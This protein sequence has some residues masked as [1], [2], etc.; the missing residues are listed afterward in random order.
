[1]RVWVTRTQPGADRTAARLR[2]LGHEPV[3]VPLLRVRRLP[4]TPDLAGVAALAFTS[5][6]GVAAYADTTEDRS[7]PVFAVGDATAAAAR[8]AGFPQVRSAGGD[9]AALTTLIA[10]AAP[11]PGALL[12]VAGRPR[13]GDLQGALVRLGVT[14]RTVTVYETTPTGAPTPERVDA[15][16]AHSPEAARRLAERVGTDAP[17][18]ALFACISDAAAAPLR[19]AGVARLAVAA[20]PD[21]AALL[22]LLT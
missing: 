18:S 4:W 13:A 12:H 17:A 2:A 20:H 22:A 21:E 16:L 5:I 6:N 7:R 1:M 14:V 9:V 10:A 8:D 3:V 19:R 15:V 11:L